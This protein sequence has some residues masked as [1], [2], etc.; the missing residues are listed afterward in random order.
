MRVDRCEF[1]LGKNPMV[2]IIKNESL[3]NYLSVNILQLDI[4][5]AYIINEYINFSA[6]MLFQII[7][8]ACKK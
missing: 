8:P 3:Y 1:I 7:E 5:L 4:L 6:C 2:E